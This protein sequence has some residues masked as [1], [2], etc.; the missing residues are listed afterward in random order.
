MFRLR[1]VAPSEVHLPQSQLDAME[2]VEHIERAWGWTGIEPFKVVAENDFG[3][4]LVR[5]RRGWYWRLCPEDLYCKPVADDRAALD[6]LIET[7]EFQQDWGRGTLI[8]QA[9][10]SVGPLSPGRKYCLKI[11]GPLGGEYGGSNLASI[12]LMELIGSS[13]HIAFQIKDMPDGAQ[14][15]LQIID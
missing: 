9:Q 7:A 8:E 4:L 5:D 10:A 12:S 11:P 1:L 6:A 2:L 15:Q 3:N 13:G 14:V